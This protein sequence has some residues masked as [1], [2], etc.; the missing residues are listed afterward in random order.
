VPELPGVASWAFLPFAFALIRS[1]FLHQNDV[2]SMTDRHLDWRVFNFD[3]SERGRDELTV[4]LDSALWLGRTSGV[5]YAA[6][7]GSSDHPRFSK[8]L[9]V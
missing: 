8:G 7:P 6:P 9:T 1:T 3:F 4:L 5:A 2:P